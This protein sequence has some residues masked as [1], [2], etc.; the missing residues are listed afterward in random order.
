MQYHG[1]EGQPIG[2][3]VVTWDAPITLKSQRTETG[4]TAALDLPAGQC[5]LLAGTVAILDLRLLIMRHGVV[6]RWPRGQARITLLAKADAHLWSK[7]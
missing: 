6:A 1:G 4:E 7:G 2:D 5:L 3:G